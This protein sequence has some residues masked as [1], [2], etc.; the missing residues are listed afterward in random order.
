[1]EIF[2]QDSGRAS[3]HTRAE[4]LSANDFTVLFNDT[5]GSQA[6]LTCTS[7]FYHN[8][9]E[10]EARI[11]NGFFSSR[12]VTDRAANDLD[13]FSWRCNSVDSNC[14]LAWRID[15]SQRD[16]VGGVILKLKVGVREADGRILARRNI[17]HRK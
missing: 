17:G 3:I 15:C 12:A 1:M 13:R 10:G 14:E 5:G 11:V 16:W 7:L 6:Y 8:L 4:G 2:A 9:A